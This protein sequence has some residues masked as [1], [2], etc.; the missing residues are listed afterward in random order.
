MWHKNDG[1]ESFTAVELTSACDGAWALHAADVDGD[2]DIDLVVSSIDDTTIRWVDN[3]GENMFGTFEWEVFAPA[4]KSS[5][6]RQS[7]LP[8]RRMS[9]EPQQV[10]TITA[11]ATKA[12][13]LA[14]G[15]VDGDNDA[16]IISALSD[17][18][19]VVW[20]RAARE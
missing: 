8:H 14:T 16:D 5:S 3:R 9:R 19:S 10:H 12:Y 13:G 11:S 1:S 4:W 18:D 15:D 2:S 6:T 17:A 7:F 20:H